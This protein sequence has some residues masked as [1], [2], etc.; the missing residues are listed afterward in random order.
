MHLSF[1]ELFNPTLI[2]VGGEKWGLMS[3]A[4]LMGTY[5]AFFTNKNIEAQSNICLFASIL[6]SHSLEC[7]H[8]LSSISIY[9]NLETGRLP[10]TI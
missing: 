8:F 9:K 4:S 2:W 3:F 1:A 5:P 10:R 7:T 6:L